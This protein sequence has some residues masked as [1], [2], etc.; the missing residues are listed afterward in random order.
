MPLLLPDGLGGRAAGVVT[1]AVVLTGPVLTDDAA[2]RMHSW[3]EFF[4]K[5]SK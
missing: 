4:N 5:K 3:Y 2:E 1:A